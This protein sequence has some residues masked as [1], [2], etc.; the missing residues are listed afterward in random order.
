MDYSNPKIPEGINY[1]R[2]H[3]LKEFA[4]LTFGIFGSIA[5]LIVIVSFFADRLAN[6]IP[7]RYESIIP[8]DKLIGP[9][10]DGK[11]ADYLQKLADKL[12]AQMDLPKNMK[13]SVH[14]VDSDTVNAF[15]T[16]N[17]NVVFF[18]GLLGKLHSENELAMV[19]AHE[20]AHV[21]YRHPIRSM[22]SGIVIGILLS[23][24]GIA[25]DSDIVT[26]LVSTSSSLTQLKFSRTHE[27]EAD[28]A[29]IKTVTRV[30]GHLNGTAD[31]FEELEKQQSKH[32]PPEFF[33]THPDTD[34]RIE[35]IH[36]TE[37]QQ[38]LPTDGPLTMLPK[39]FSEWL[40][41]GVK[42]DKPNKSFDK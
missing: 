11:M 40:N 5:V 4:L 22:G 35:M 30:Y 32:A 20:I 6:H 12:V 37:H 21:K 41:E 1:S 17:G 18:R 25:V 39:Q 7:Y 3:P 26:N 10:Q 2:E 29:A 8:I 28:R 19:M 15:A 34:N 13:I 9:T 16:L 42:Q 33:N 27:T 24:A 38:G 36:Q 31:L 14:Y 23:V